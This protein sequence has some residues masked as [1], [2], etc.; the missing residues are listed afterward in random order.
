[1]F[2]VNISTQ[3][4]Y[5]LATQNLQQI[6]HRDIFRKRSFPFSNSV[7]SISN[8]TKTIW[9][10]NELLKQRLAVQALL[11]TQLQVVCITKES[12]VE[13]LGSFQQRGG[14]ETDCVWDSSLHSGFHVS[15]QG[16]AS[17]ARDASRNFCINMCYK[18]YIDPDL[19]NHHLLCHKMRWRG[20]TLEVLFTVPSH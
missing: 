19:Y 1:M 4:A 5:A 6:R 13:F 17:R 9:L 12:Y 3:T 8:I 2:K 10:N 18:P 14:K 15:G 20:F 16:Y 7:T 11:Q